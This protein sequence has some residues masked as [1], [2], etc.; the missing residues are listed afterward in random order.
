MTAVAWS[1]TRDRLAAAVDVAR[2]GGLVARIAVGSGILRRLNGLG[3]PYDARYT[4]AV[5]A[6]KN[7]SANENRAAL[8]AWF[9]P[10]F[11]SID[12]AA[13]SA[14]AQQ[15]AANA[16]HSAT[17]Y[18]QKLL[19]QGFGSALTGEQVVLLTPT[20]SLPPVTE[21]SEPSPAFLRIGDV[22]VTAKTPGLLGNRI[23]I[24]IADPE[25]PVVLNPFTG[26]PIVLHPDY[27]ADFFKLT[28][29]LGG[30]EEV[31]PA[32]LKA[33]AGFFGLLL[34]PIEW[35]VS[36][37]PSRPENGTYKLNGG[38]G[39]AVGE[40][41]ARI[42]RAL[43]LPVIKADDAS[44]KLISDFRAQ[45]IA[46]Q[47]GKPKPKFLREPYASLRPFELELAEAVAEA[48]RFLAF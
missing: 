38:A 27:I 39:D 47:S 23:V 48:T 21:V 26:D 1:D 35:S 10:R 42:N 14:E 29:S 43:V 40:L 8:E 44:K 2:R 18:L 33:P 4:D 37:P 7:A 24:T 6:A 46:M 36:P 3:A 34:A 41:L 5:D 45:A 22:A 17:P 12:D 11:A 19:A 15:V 30:Y 25:F 28:V 20:A 16:V 31:A 9:G 32:A 13:R